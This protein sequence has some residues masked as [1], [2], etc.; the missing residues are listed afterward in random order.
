MR[1]GLFDETPFLLFWETTRAC[2]LACQHCRADAVPHRSERELDTAEGKAL[3][4]SAKEM[5]V[6]LVVLTGG[7]PA[8][9]EDLIELVRYGTSIGLRMALTP[10]ATP[11]VT[12]ELLGRLKDAGLA[13]LAVSLDSAVPAVHD[14]FRGFSG[15]HARTLEILRAARALGLTTQVNTSVGPRNLAEMP[16]IAELIAALDVELWSVFV[17]VPTGRATNEGAL[18]A[19]QIESML[20]WLAELSEHARFDVKT[21]AAPQFRR[22]LLQRK[23]ARD[24]IVGIRDGIGRAPRGVNDGSG[25]VFVSHEGDVFPSGF[26][27]LRCGNVRE[28]GLVRIYR[29]HPLFRSLRAPD[30]L[31]G[32][33]GR[34]EFR[35]VCGGSRARAYAT[36]LS[37]LASDPG[38]AY[39]PVH[40]K[41]DAGP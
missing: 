22:V 16:K 17:V 15:S 9:R 31:T 38:C 19:D 20:H 39:E 8:K 33:C 21:T 18:T 10:S 14:A 24:D 41:L 32:K 3:L 37:P 5:G 25:V 26:L 27:P 12:Q 29:E 30:E 35:Y 34:C 36:K 23:H 6:P 4:D 7:D 2:D 11:L 1:R 28:E 13:R 40:P